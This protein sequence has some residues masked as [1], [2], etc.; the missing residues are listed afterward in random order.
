MTLDPRRQMA[1]QRTNPLCSTS[2][3]RSEGQEG[4]S[5]VGALL[6]IIRRQN[7]DIL[8]KLTAAQDREEEVITTRKLVP[9]RLEVSFELFCFE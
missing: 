6:A 4:D 3:T 5:G 1:S 9:K 8:T 7:E 2:G